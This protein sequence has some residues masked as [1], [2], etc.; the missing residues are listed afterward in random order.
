MC[1]VDTTT[2]TDGTVTVFCY[3]GWHDYGHATQESADVAA[4]AH[5]EL[6]DADPYAQFHTPD[7]A[8]ADDHTADV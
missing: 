4:Y 5:Q 8:D 7:T 6:A 2:E 1:I 3:C